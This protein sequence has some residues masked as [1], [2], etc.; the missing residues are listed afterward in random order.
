[1]STQI[2]QSFTKQFEADVHLAYQQMGSKLKNTVRFK[3][4]VQGSSTVFQKVGKGVASGKARH[5]LVP[6][7]SI[8]H[9]PV[10]CEL[11]D[12]YAGD[13][14]D[15]LDELKISIDERRIIASAG[16][17]A[18]GRKTDDL[19]IEALSKAP[20][21]NDVGDY[22]KVLTKK[23]ILDAF[24]KLNENDVP[25][26]GQRFGLVGPHQWNALL[27]V[28]EFSNSDYAGDNL[29]FLKGT[30]SRKWLGINWV[31]HTGLPLTGSGKSQRDCFIFHKTAVG[32]ASGQDVKSDISWHG[33]HAAHFV[34][35]MM[36]QGACLIDGTGVVRI[37]CKEASSVA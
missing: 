13:W 11:Q 3:N 10:E 8:D 21:T 37:K 35:N 2:S 16:A 36:S 7:M 1:M 12:Y 23:D 32:H 5:G 29:P 4:K 14:V 30:E 31:M 28:P 27:N 34:N 15:A 22:T 20:S 33:D 19:I 6:V 18:L 26:D 9:T 17:Y 24:A 25:D